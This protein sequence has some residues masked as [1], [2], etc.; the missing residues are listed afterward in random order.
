MKIIYSVWEST[1]YVLEKNFFVPKKDLHFIDDAAEFLRRDDAEAT[2]RSITADLAEWEKGKGGATYEFIVK[3][4]TRY[5]LHRLAGDETGAGRENVCEFKSRGEAYALLQLLK[6]TE[7]SDETKALI[8]SDLAWAPYMEVN[9]QGVF[10]PRASYI[11]NDLL[12]Q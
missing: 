1:R 7:A 6:G 10:G 4:V 5:V 12:A 2:L 9:D 8:K 3:A 11:V